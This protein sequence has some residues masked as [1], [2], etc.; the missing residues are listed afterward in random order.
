MMFLVVLEV[1]MRWT[2]WAVLTSEKWWKTTHFYGFLEKPPKVVENH[3]F[4]GFSKKQEKWWKTTHFD[5]F[6]GKPEKWWFSTTFYG[7]SI[8]P[9]K[10]VENHPFSFDVGGFLKK[11]WKTT[12]FVRFL[13]YYFILYL[14]YFLEKTGKCGGKPPFFRFFKKTVKMVEN[15]P[16]SRFFQKTV[17][18]GGFPPLL[19]VF[20]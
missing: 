2:A 5:G 7:F 19:T 10:V 11:W 9:P 1:N 8:K 6:F 20:P 17:K 15:H 14:C 13:G 18:S 4:S 3:H 16:F 12:H